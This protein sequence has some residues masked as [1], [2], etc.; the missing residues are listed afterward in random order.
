MKK[1]YPILFVA[2]LF[3]FFVPVFAQATTCDQTAKAIVDVSGGCGKIDSTLYKNIYD[4]C[5]TSVTKAGLLQLLNDALADGALSRAEISS[6]LGALNSYLSAIPVPTQITGGGDTA[7]ESFRNS[8]RGISDDGAVIQA[9]CQ[10]IDGSWVRASY[11]RV[12]CSTDIANIDGTL[13]CQPVGG[14]S[15]NDTATESFRNS[16]RTIEATDFFIRAECQRIDGSWARVYY[17]RVGCSTDIA[18]MDGVLTCAPAGGGGGGG[19]APR[20]GCPSYAP[21][22]G[23]GTC[24]P[25]SSACH[26][27]NTSSYSDDCT[28]CRKCP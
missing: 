28:S 8:C 27:R 6:L 14:G 9:E 1:I 12:G 16:C 17:G 24:W 7:A 15:R 10:K 20:T 13:V 5:C 22:L 21:W 25:S 18:N 26:S 2:G 19:C 23:C 11:R 4:A 3:A